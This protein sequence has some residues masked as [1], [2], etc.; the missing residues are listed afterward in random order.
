MLLQIAALLTLIVM[1]LINLAIGI[2]PHV[3]N[4]AHIGGFLTGILLGFILLP[5]PQ[6]G[7]LERQNPAAGVRLRSK[8]KAYQYVLLVI[9][10]VL[11][12]AG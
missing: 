2:L 6:F 8:Y 9:S 1:I 12:I 5:R 4:F 11:V 10:L 3:D 7:W